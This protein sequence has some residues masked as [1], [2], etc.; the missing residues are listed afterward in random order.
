MTDSGNYTNQREVFTEVNIGGEGREFF[1]IPS[2][3]HPGNEASWTVRV[4]WRANSG[5]KVQLRM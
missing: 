4:F 3:F 5:T 2:T 1:I